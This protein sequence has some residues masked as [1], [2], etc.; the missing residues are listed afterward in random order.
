MAVLET[1]NMQPADRGMLSLSSNSRHLNLT[2][3]SLM[4]GEGGTTILAINQLKE[5]PR[6][7]LDDP[8]LTEH[9]L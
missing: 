3:R 8:W 5:I 4:I 7:L 2:T 6:L 1:G 9:T